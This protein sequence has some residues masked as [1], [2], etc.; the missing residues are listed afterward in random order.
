MSRSSSSCVGR[1]SRSSLLPIRPSRPRAMRARSMLSVERGTPCTAAACERIVLTYPRSMPKVT[2]PAPSTACSLP[3]WINRSRSSSCSCKR[4]IL[5]SRNVRLAFF[6]RPIRFPT[7]WRSS[8]WRR[9]RSPNL[10]SSRE[11]TASGGSPR[12][13]RRSI[14]SA[15]SSASLRRRNV[16]LTYFPFRRTWTRHEPDLSLLKV[17]TA[18]ALRVH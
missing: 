14:S 13:M 15:H 10:L 11:L 9:T 1:R 18:C 17:A 7:S 16:S 6:D 12:S 3:N 5:S 4:P 2:G 8:R